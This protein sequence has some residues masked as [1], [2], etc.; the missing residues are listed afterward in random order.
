MTRAVA[1]C[2][3]PD[4]I[5][6]A[7]AFSPVQSIQEA[8]GENAVSV[9]SCQG[10][11]GSIYNIPTAQS[12]HGIHKAL[13]KIGTLSHFL[14]VDIRAGIKTEH[15]NQIPVIA[16]KLIIFFIQK[17]SL[18]KN[19]KPAVL[20]PGRPLQDLPLH[21]RLSTGE[22]E[23]ADTQLFRLP[24]QNIPLVYRHELFLMFRMNIAVLTTWTGQI[25]MDRNICLQKYRNMNPGFP[26]LQTPS[27]C[28]GPGNFQV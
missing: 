23:K 25:A 10:N 12:I 15:G 3:I 2:L 16:E 20:I 6:D 17:R 9:L 27:G 1:V 4:E 13:I 14:Q 21:Q 24:E 5:E 11:A 28:L 7:V 18:R 22:K 19:Q 8:S 26:C